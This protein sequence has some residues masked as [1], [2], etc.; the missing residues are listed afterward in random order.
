[1]CEAEAG[2]LSNDSAMSLALILN[3][4]L[5][6]AAKYSGDANEQPVIRANLTGDAGCYVLSVEDGGP[7]FDLDAVRHRTSGLGLVQGLAAKVRGRLQVSRHPSRV[8]IYFED[9]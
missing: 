1:M 8:S 4:L 2:E 7:G 9:R 3:E 5:V 6:N